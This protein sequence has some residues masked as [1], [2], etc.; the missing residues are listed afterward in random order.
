MN[1]ADVA[2][3]VALNIPKEPTSEE[4]A[5][6]VANDPTEEGYVWNNPLDELSMYKLYDFFN[7]SIVNRGD[8][9]TTK[10]MDRLVEWA[11][12]KGAVEYHEVISRV[13]E[14]Q[15]LLG[16]SDIKDLYR[17]VKLDMQREKIDAEMRNIYG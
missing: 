3:K 4:P 15:R 6:A 11:M 2:A 5:V 1:E 8:H 9:E 10:M 17:F 13:R 12:A 14:I 7:V 16:K